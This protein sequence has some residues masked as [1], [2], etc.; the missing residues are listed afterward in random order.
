MSA[1]AVVAVIDAQG[2]EHGDDVAVVDEAEVDAWQGMLVEERLRRVE[3]KPAHGARVG[4]ARA[5]AIE[6]E[7]VPCIFE[8]E[9]LMRGEDGAPRAFAAGEDLEAAHLHHAV[10]LERGEMQAGVLGCEA[11]GDGG[12]EIRL[13]GR[14]LAVAVVVAGVFV[15]DVLQTRVAR[16]ERVGAESRRFGDDVQFRRSIAGPVG[17]EEAVREIS[18]CLDIS[19]G[20][21]G[22][23]VGLRLRTD[24]MVVEPAKILTG[25]KGL[26]GAGVWSGRREI[27][28]VFEVGEVGPIIQE[29]K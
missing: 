21:A 6:V 4:I 26:D 11:L 20:A 8:L 7:Q 1:A 3:P 18:R 16:R 24:Q 5:G 14:Q 19:W 12:S 28:Q 9:P 22:P 2:D 25:C 27:F 13:P 29:C 17:P 15:C 23:E 10:D